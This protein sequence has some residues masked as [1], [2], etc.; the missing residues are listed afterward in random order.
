[1]KVYIIGWDNQCDFTEVWGVAGTF[2]EAKEMG[3]AGVIDL[4]DNRR[5]IDFDDTEISEYAN[6]L[7]IE[8]WDI[9]STE[10]LVTHQ[11]EIKDND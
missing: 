10:P 1:M 2:E 3:V 5:N 11:W 6:V 4:W 8:E 7:Y 9:P